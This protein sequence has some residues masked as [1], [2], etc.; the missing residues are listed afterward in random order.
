M[1]SPSQPPLAGQSPTLVSFDGPTK[2]AFPSSL[3]LGL[4]T[5]GETS[6][7]YGI[8]Q[9]CSYCGTSGSLFSFDPTSSTF[10]SLTFGAS[11]GLSYP[12][13]LVQGE[14]SNGANCD[15]NLYGTA[16]L[17]GDRCSSSNSFGCGGVFEYSVS[18]QKD[19]LLCTFGD[20]QDLSAS[21][22]SVS[23]LAPNH[24]SPKPDTVIRQSGTRFPFDLEWSFN[25]VPI[26]L[27]E[28]SDGS[29]L[30]TTPWACFSGDGGY[31]VGAS[32]GTGA[33]DVAT[34]FQCQPLPSG[35]TPSTP[36][37]LNTI[38]PFTG[39]SVPDGNVS[40][41]ETDGGGSLAGI[42]LASDGNYYGSSGNGIFEIPAG[43][44][45]GFL[46]SSAS[47][48]PT[49]L[50]NL[51][52]FALLPSADSSSWMIQGSNGNFY[53]TSSTGGQNSDGV[54]YEVAPSNSIP[55]P[56]QLTVTT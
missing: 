29:I 24:L 46:T 2:G 39:E 47:N 53:G 35:S 33:D 27:T 50:S 36:W 26:A 37:T 20:S 41:N 12:N 23:D 40:G 3:T 6:V 10:E 54:L 15:L 49:Q 22:V 1:I 17:G 19:T 38:Y 55:V 31:L 42:T 21:A 48:P 14:C 4:A 32:C 51:N 11:S 28:S 18:T 7:L 16:Q 43:S 44:M 13:S 25:S 34:V 8:S 30:G 9:S 52:P 5:D 56:V 45:N